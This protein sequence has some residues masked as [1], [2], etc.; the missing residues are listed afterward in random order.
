MAQF[1]TRFEIG[2]AIV[3]QTDTGEYT[4]GEIFGIHV[5]IC[6]NGKPKTERY[7]VS[8]FDDNG[9]RLSD[10]VTVTARKQD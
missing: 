3:F 7:Q 6:Q 5:Y 4:S 8:Y 10:W 2:D 9:N 1:T